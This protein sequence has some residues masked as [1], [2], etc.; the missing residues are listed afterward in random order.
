MMTT[1]AE[2]EVNAVDVESV[3]IG[4]ASDANGANNA[5][6]MPAQMRNMA[7]WIE[8]NPLRKWLDTNGRYNQRM[9]A[10]VLSLRD[11]KSVV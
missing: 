10:T 7:A 4:V 3:A 11:R 1:D 2:H 6:P 5:G 8:E 9:L